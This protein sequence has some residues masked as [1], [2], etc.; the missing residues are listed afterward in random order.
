MCVACDLDNDV[1]SNFLMFS[2][3]NYYFY[4]VNNHYSNCIADR[5][6]HNS[7]NY[8]DDNTILLGHSLACIAPM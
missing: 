1:I 5:Y 7:D 8:S 4:L 3:N 2:V 6:V